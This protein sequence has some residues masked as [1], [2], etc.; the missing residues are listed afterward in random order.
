MIIKR[1]HNFLLEGIIEDLRDRF[2]S[3]PQVDFDALVDADPTPQKKYLRKLLQ[4]YIESYGVDILKDLIASYHDMVSRNII[5]GQ[6]R[7]IQSFKDFQ[8]FED[9]V[10]L[11]KYKKTGQEKKRAVSKGESKS[12][13]IVYQD[14]NV[15]V[16]K[17]FDHEASCAFGKNTKWCITMNSD[18]YWKTYSNSNLLDFYFVEFVKPPKKN[19]KKVAIGVNP[20]NEIQELRDDKDND[21]DREIFFGI[22]NLPREMFVN[23][24]NKESKSVYELIAK[25]ERVGIERFK[26]LDLEKNIIEVQQ[27]IDIKMQLPFHIVRVVGDCTYKNM[28]IAHVPEVTGKLTVENSAF[29]KILSIKAS[30]VIIDRCSGLQNVSLRECKHVNIISSYS[31][32][33]LTSLDLP[34]EMEYLRVV[35]CGLISLQGSPKRVEE[36]F[37]LYFNDLKTL[38]HGPEYVGQIYSVKANE[39]KSLEGLKGEFN[40]LDATM[41]DIE[42]EEIPEGAYIKKLN[43][44]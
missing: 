13:E 38:E 34:S 26:V 15:T 17:I 9:V 30:K 43:V 19:W 5:Q 35:K 40:N 37:I 6:D 16:R 4:F 8:S 7:D 11:N 44:K 23:T 31:I 27:N 20:R 42:S 39:L 22:T 14:N 3:I 29:D 36:D 21:I 41:N 12:S 33:D 28:S 1:F 18:G 2:Q 25:L 10:V 24:F 32:K